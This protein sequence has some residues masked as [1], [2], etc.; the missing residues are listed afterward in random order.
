MINVNAAGSS[1]VDWTYAPEHSKPRLVYLS[2]GS[3]PGTFDYSDYW[4]KFKA[5]LSVD[6]LWDISLTPT[7]NN[8]FLNMN[9]S[10]TYH[11]RQRVVLSS[12]SYNF[13]RYMDMNKSATTIILYASG[14]TLEFEAVA[15]S[16]TY[17]VTVD[18]EFDVTG[19]SKLDEL[20]ISFRPTSSWYNGDL[21]FRISN[22]EVSVTSP[23]D[24]VI[25]NDN[26]N[27]EEVKGFWNNLFSKLGDWFK[28]LLDGIL[29]GLK[30]LFIPKDGFMEQF[31]S[32]V[33][34]FLKEHLGALYYPFSVMIDILQK[35][36]AFKPPDNPSITLPALSFPVNG[37]TY[38]LWEDTVYNFDLLKDEPFKTIYSFYLMAVDCMFAFALVKLFKKKL[39]EVMIG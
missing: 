6:Y 7:G 22:T 15:V 14:R 25:A 39:D 8:L 33:D 30:S 26:K 36:L 4:Y 29:N 23:N 34:N 10:Y 37:T 20:G 21:W 5:D 24:D 31:F 19:I 3:V 9:P 18:F 2:G 27:H 32:D 1:T 11:I 35:I 13:S 38:T 17:A 28:G 12:G 16:G